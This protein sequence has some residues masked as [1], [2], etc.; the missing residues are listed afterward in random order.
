MTAI[1]LTQAGRLEPIGELVARMEALAGGGTP[2]PRCRSGSSGSPPSGG[3]SRQ[4]APRHAT[5]RAAQRSA[6]PPLPRAAETSFR[7]PEPADRGRSTG[8]GG[9]R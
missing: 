2:T 5:E 8:G 4:A 7:S 6:M 9:A 3:R 1:Q